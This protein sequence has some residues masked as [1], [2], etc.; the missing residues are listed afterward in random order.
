MECEVATADDVD[1]TNQQSPEK[2]SGALGRKSVSYVCDTAENDNPAD[3]NGDG[4]A[5]RERHQHGHNSQHNH[6]DGPPNGHPR[7]FLEY[8]RSALCSHLSSPFLILRGTG[9]IHAL[10]SLREFN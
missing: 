2:C 8:I 10:T 6:D 5:S 4:D 7:G 3:K 9:G 1:E